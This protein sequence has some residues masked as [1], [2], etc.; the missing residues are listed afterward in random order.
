[1]TISIDEQV[2][3]IYRRTLTRAHKVYLTKTNKEAQRHAKKQ[4]ELDVALATEIATLVQGAADEHRDILV[5]EGLL[6]KESKPVFVTDVEE[7]R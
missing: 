2:L 4:H 6:P 3:N 5:L 1:M 7:I